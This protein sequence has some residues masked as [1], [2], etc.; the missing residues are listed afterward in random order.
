M[1][2]LYGIVKN[3]KGDVKLMP[4]A[5]WG[6]IYNYF[7]NLPSEYTHDNLKAYKSLEAFNF[8]VYNYVQDIYYNEIAKKSEFWILQYQNK[9]TKI[10]I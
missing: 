3:W 2:D 5:S 6:D 8:F 10:F 7:I 1:P 9:G 4:D